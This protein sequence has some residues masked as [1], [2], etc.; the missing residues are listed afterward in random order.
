MAAVAVAV[1]PSGDRKVS[2][3]VRRQGSK[4]NVVL[5]NSYGLPAGLSCPHMTDFCEGC[6]AEA[7]ENQWSSVSRL[8]MSNWQAHQRAG[9]NVVMH[10]VLLMSQFVV[11]LL[12]F[13]RLS[14]QGRVTDDDL[15]YRIH[16]DGDLYS[17][18]YTLAWRRLIQGHPE[19]RFWIYTR[20]FEYATLL[21]D[22]PNVAVY[23]SVDEYNVDAAEKYLDAF[24]R[25]HAAFCAETQAD[26]AVLAASIGRRA[27]ACPENVGRIPLVMHQSGRRTLSVPVGEDGKGACAAC[28]LCVDGVRDVAFATSKR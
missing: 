18:A 26:A 5:Q 7:L 6:Y 8:V 21:E 10:L 24:P 2:S 27:V 17:E 16:W 13:R 23:L 15:I 9:D 14:E 3:C 4:D 1:R 19:V 12:Q 22:L 25:L 28:R 20:S 11:F